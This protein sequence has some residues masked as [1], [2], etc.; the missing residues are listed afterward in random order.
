MASNREELGS[1]FDQRLWLSGGRNRV[2]PGTLRRAVGVA[3]ELTGSVMSRWGSQNL[4]PISAIS[5]YKWNNHRYAYN[6]ST[7]YQDGTS[8]QAAINAATGASGFSGGRLSFVEAPPQVGLQD[9]LFVLGGGVKPFK[10]APDGTVSLWGIGAPGNGATASVGTTETIVIDNMTTNQTANWSANANCTLL[11]DA[12]ADDPFLS[13]G[14]YRVDMT[15]AG[16]PWWIT[17]QYGSPQDWS[18]YGDGTISL[19]SDL[20]SIY[21]QFFR[22]DRTVWF[23]IL[24]DVDDGTFK[25]NYYKLVVQVTATT[26][27]PHTAGAAMILTPAANQWIQI[28]AAKN[29]FQRI[30]SNLNLDWS[31]VQAVRLEGGDPTLD[32]ARCFFNG[33]QLYG[34]YP[35]GIGPAA[36]LGGSEYQYAVTFGNSVTGSVSNP[37]GMQVQPDGSVSPPTPFVA[38]GVA[39]QPVTLNHLP[40]SSDPQVNERLLWRTTAGGSLFSYLD[41]VPD[42]STTTYTDITGDLPGQPV[43][44]TPWT[45]NVNVSSNGYKVDGGNGFWFK[46][47]GGGPPGTTGATIPSWNIPTGPF[48]NDWRPDITYSVGDWVNYP[49][50]QPGT[51][52]GYVVLIQNRGVPP[53]T[54]LGTDW[55][56]I[57]TTMDNT[58]TW[59]WG[60][61][62]AVRTLALNNNLLYDNQ[63]PLITYGDVSGLFEGGVFWTRDSTTGRQGWVYASPP[64]RPESVGTSFVVSSNDAPVQRVVIW[65]ELP[66]ALATKGVYVI[67]GSYPAFSPSILKGGLG[68]EWPYTVVVAQNGVYYRAPDGIRMFDRGGSILAGFQAISPILRGRSAENVQPFY[69]VWGALT[70]DEVYFGDNT[71]TFALSGQSP[72]DLIHAASY[73]WRMLGQALLCAFYERDD[74]EILASFGGNTLLYEH[75]GAL[76]DST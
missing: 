47:T 22:P 28:A 48:L 11:F 59:A 52:T 44:V 68:T 14:C 69:A 64:G 42:N 32:P 34:G 4:W 49:S 45:K 63:Q 65:D 39:L 15:G 70:R 74:D 3:P 23:W 6:G 25:N 41:T 26:N 76:S 31:N 30:G 10:I 55:Q 40:I 18:Q 33:F 53:T 35:L 61:I 7:L 57:G 9:Y 24:V 37:N 21:A 73:V 51:G 20:I 13:G 2:P 60:G 16:A 50:G 12:A 27:N 46:T 66:W 56:A 8:I 1:N 29:Q 62:N 43:I 58:V 38:Q 36:L 17:K 75:T 54:S 19:Q 71:V 67:Q 5:V 72:V